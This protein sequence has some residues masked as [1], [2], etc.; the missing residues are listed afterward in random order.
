[1]QNSREEV[2]EL[3]LLQMNKLEYML[4]NYRV[5]THMFLL[6]SMSV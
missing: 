4:D 5:D 3:D 6:F 1:M 2:G